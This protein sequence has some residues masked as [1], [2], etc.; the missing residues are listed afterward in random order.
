LFPG[1]E[2]LGNEVGRAGFERERTL[3]GMV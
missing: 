3:K 1:V 2:N